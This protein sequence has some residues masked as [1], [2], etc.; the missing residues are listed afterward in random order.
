[1]PGVSNWPGLI[2]AFRV[3]RP[4]RRVPCSRTDGS[5]PCST[6]RHTSEGTREAASH[7]TQAACWC[8][9]EVVS[10]S[11]QSASVNSGSKTLI[12]FNIATVHR[13]AWP[14]EIRLYAVLVGPHAYGD[15]QRAGSGGPQRGRAPPPP[16]PSSSPDQCRKRVSQQ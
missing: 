8:V 9:E 14:D 10:A 12:Y 2:V 13:L 4:S 5:A 3:P 6:R 7:Q 1:M 15:A 16:R 11:V